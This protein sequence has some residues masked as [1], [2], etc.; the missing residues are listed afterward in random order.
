MVKATSRQHSVINSIIST[1]GYISGNN[2]AKINQISV[3]TVQR[4]IKSINIFL[5][6]YKCE[7]ISK[8]SYGYK[9][10]YESSDDYEVLKNEL[11]KNDSTVIRTPEEN[12][13]HWLIKKLSFLY[14]DGDKESIKL[15]E[16]SNKL[17]ISIS[18]LPILFSTFSTAFNISLSSS[19]SAQI[20]SAPVAL[21][22]A[23]AASRDC[24]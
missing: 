22:S 21:E 16:L 11:M 19:E 17:F 18:T 12:R 14:I 7:I 23:L 15:E 20:A 4:E 13:V 3:K 2:L 24:L 5:K 8:K 9:F 10:K 6:Q 1:D